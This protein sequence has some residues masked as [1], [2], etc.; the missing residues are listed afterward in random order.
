MSDKLEKR[1]K[2]HSSRLQN[3]NYGWNGSYFVTICTSDRIHYFGE[4]EDGKMKF[5][6]IGIIAKKFWHEILNHVQHVKLDAF[7]VMP[8]HIHGIL[9]LDGNNRRDKAVNRRDKA[10]LVPTTT[11]NSNKSSNNLSQ[12][13]GQ[14]RF[15]NQGKNTVSS[16][17]GSYKS[18]VT[19][20]AHR[21]GF[22]FA[23]QARFHDHIIRDKSEFKRIQN[24]ILNNPSNW[25][26]DKLNSQ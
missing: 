17:I 25:N 5:S 2:D 23:W 12:T 14:T 20:H 7:V 13:I 18:A 11:T 4:I 24:Y 9:I 6:G 19:K 1:Y 3:W 16:I 21:L 10:C 8:N 22:D 15:Q 26:D